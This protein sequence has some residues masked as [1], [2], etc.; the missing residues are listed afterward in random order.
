MWPGPLSSRAFL[1]DGLRKCASCLGC[2]EMFALPL[3]VSWSRGSQ[4]TL[5][6]SES[7]LNSLS[8]VGPFP[9]NDNLK[10]DSTLL[11]RGSVSLPALP[12]QL[13]SWLTIVSLH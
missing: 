12:A 7:V 10:S 2:L 4:T 3:V 13:G 6:V 1:P 8:K 9:L 5:S 11:S